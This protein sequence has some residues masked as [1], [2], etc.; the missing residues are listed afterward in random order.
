MSDLVAAPSVPEG[1]GQAEGQVVEAP[2]DAGQAEES[3]WSG[4]SY[5]WP[6]GKKEEYK[7]R[8]DLDR[9]FKGSYLRQS[10]YT[11]KTQA[12]SELQKSYEQQKTDL[13]KQREE[14]EA[15]AKEHENYRKMVESR[16]D[17]RQK[18][19][20]EFNRVPSPDV[21]VERSQKY[22]DE[23]YA[24]LEKELQEMKEWR[25][26]QELEREWQGLSGKLSEE[27]P[28]FDGDAVREL[29]T[30]VGSGDL[31]TVAR[32]LHFARLGQQNPIETEKRI[33]AS[34]A[35]KQAGKL[36]SSKNKGPKDEVE[37]SSFDEGERLALEAFGNT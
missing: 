35:E 18:L 22:A 14:I 19:A 27:L 13:Q 36:M 30:Q 34:A 12:L 16:P 8:E 5:T 37:P 31:E 25:R 17:L 24:A 21:A 4:Y 2:V 32:T 6:D 3:Q 7:T 33:A 15:I 29:L 26:E 23:K 1:E 9:A 28:G 10:D 11:K 20:E